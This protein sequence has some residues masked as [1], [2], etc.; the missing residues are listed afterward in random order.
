MLFVEKGRLIFDA[1]LTAQEYLM[2]ERVPLGQIFQLIFDLLRKRPNAIVYGSQ[3][4]NAYV[5][6]PRMTEDIDIFTDDAPRLAEDICHAIHST[7]HIA[8]RVRRA[9][10]GVGLRIYQTSKANRRHLVDIRPIQNPPPT[11]IIGGVAFVEPSA[12]AAMKVI[13]AHD[14]GHRTE[15]M[16]DLVDLKKLLAQFPTLR[17]SAIVEH[18]LRAFGASLAA[19]ELW[20]RLRAEQSPRRRMLGRRPMN[21]RS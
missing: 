16:Q 3:A 7:F 15:G 2:H 5:S 11:R 18:H 4:I 9:K 6:P 14:R 17:A 21:Y 1:P 20:A 19:H 10:N 12:L 8:V 13:S